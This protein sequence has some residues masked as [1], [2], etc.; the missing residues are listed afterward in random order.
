M[1]LVIL[2][3][4]KLKKYIDTS[5][6]CSVLCLDIQSC[7]TFCHPVD[8]SPPGFSNHEDSP[9]KNTGVGCHA[10][11]QGTFPTQGSNPDLPHCRWILYH[12]S[13]QESPYRYIGDFISIHNVQPPFPKVTLYFFF[14]LLC[15]HSVLPLF[16]KFTEQLLHA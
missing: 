14:L 8:C 11:L 13:Y 6:V 10:L 9:G 1:E 16:H 15:I 2:A 3:F 12:L 5:A 4:I 7:P